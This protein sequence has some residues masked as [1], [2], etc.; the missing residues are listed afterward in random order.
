MRPAVACPTGL[1]GS[2]DCTPPPVIF[3]QSLPKKRLGFGLQSK[4]PVFLERFV[5]S[6]DD[7]GEGP[8]TLSAPFKMVDLST[9]DLSLAK[10]LKSIGAFG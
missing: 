7:K 10:R 4:S 2:S 5:Q 3:A 9:T 6:L 1:A 8:E